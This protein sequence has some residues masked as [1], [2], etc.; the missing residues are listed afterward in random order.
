MT[1][2]SLRTLAGVGALEEAITKFL[3]HT[4]CAKH[5]TGIAGG[6]GNFG[7]L[8]GQQNHHQ[9][10]AE[11]MAKF[12]EPQ[13]PRTLVNAKERVPRTRL[14]V[15]MLKPPRIS[16][17][18]LSCGQYAKSRGCGEVGRIWGRRCTQGPRYRRSMKYQRVTRCW[19]W[20]FLLIKNNAMFFPPSPLSLPCPYY[21]EKTM[22]DRPRNK[23]DGV[24]STHV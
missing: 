21:S 20:P 22:Y 5:N 14:L 13:K 16:H 17:A 19:S 6:L 10:C 4:W 18:V 12:A 15:A 3:E 2:E 23:G 8:P 24:A 9:T 7:W 1:L 11:A